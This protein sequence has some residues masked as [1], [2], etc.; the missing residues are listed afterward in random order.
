MPF[1][2][3]RL[4]SWILATLFLLLLVLLLAPQQIPVSLYKLSLITMAGVVGYW[5]DRSLF[6]DGRTSYFFH[7][8]QEDVKGTTR[9]A[10]PLAAAMLR[11][12]LM[13]A[14]AMLAISL[15]A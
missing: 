6:P 8:W 10:L 12:A 2:L 1:R 13:V 5:L 4:F 11:K 9:S 7:V 3:P 14:A 15:G